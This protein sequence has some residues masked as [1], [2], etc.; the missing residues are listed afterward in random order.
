MSILTKAAD[1]ARSPGDP[2]VQETGPSS[3]TRS[4]RLA[5]GLAWFSLGLGFLELVAPRRLAQVLGLEGKEGLIRAFG[6]REIGSGILSMSVDKQVGILSRL[7]GDAMD[8]ASLAPALGRRN[9]KRM[10]ACIAFAALGGVTLL[11]IIAATSQTALH[12][13][14]GPVRYYSDR[15]GLPRGIEAS[16]GLARKDFQTP[17][18]LRAEPAPAGAV[19]QPNGS[20]RPQGDQRKSGVQ[21]QAS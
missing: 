8:I 16:R 3:L 14:K 5:R 17:A 12:R 15:S 13:R 21:H 11:D 7:P 4:D 20:G 19:G 6:A 1:L 18:D 2:K 9:P 10:N